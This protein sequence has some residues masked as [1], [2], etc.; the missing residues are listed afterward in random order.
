MS[1]PIL[2]LE[3]L[4][5]TKFLGEGHCSEVRLG[6]C[7]LEKFV[8]K[9]PRITG[10]TTIDKHYC[11]QIHKEITIL[12]NLEHENIVKLLWA[13]KANIFN[14]LTLQ[15]INIPVILLEYAKGD[16]LYKFIE[17]SGKFSEQLSKHIFLQL[18]SALEYLSSKNIKHRDIKCEN[19]LLDTFFKTKL[20]DF[21]LST[22][23]TNNE[24][25]AIG[26]RGYMAPEVESL[27]Q[28]ASIKSDVFSLGV[29]LF[30]MIT[31]RFPFTFT[32]A[33]YH[34]KILCSSNNQFWELFE[35]PY[36]GGMKL[37]S[38]FKKLI[39]QM[40]H[41]NPSKRPTLLELKNSDWILKGEKI[42]ELEIMCE[43]NVRYGLQ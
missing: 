6:E 13:G 30:Y 8:C 28:C 25:G 17:K 10:N 20:A 32:K 18:I 2:Y 39:N 1:E 29:V 43:W 19:I 7:S 37:S 22:I 27:K 5:L 12:S 16:N 33:N 36:K 24:K 11:E 42:S 31:G 23:L 40:L 3:D 15:R 35:N 4:C 34:Y 21:D 26:T 9:I 38:E 14:T 41:V